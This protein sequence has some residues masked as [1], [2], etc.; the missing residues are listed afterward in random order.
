MALDALRGELTMARLAA[1]HGICSDE[2]CLGRIAGACVGAGAG[3]GVGGG[4][5]EVGVGV[6]PGFGEPPGVG[7]IDSGRTSRTPGGRP[8]LAVQDSRIV[9]AVPPRE[10]GSA[11]LQ[12]FLVEARVQHHDASRAA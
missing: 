3:A 7:L 1:K 10:T 6:P 2:A 5:D 8:V 9:A 12:N 4:A 11:R